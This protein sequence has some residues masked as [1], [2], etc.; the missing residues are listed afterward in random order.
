MRSELKDAGSTL[1]PA[2]AVVLVAAALAAV[3]FSRPVT[4]P[5]TAKRTYTQSVSYEYQ[6]EVPVG[7]TYP[8]GIVTTG[9]P[10]FLRLV[11]Q[12]QFHLAYQ[13]EARKLHGVVGTYSID[14]RVSG[15]GSWKGYIPLTERTRFTGESF[16]ADVTVDI[17]KVQAMIAATQAETGLRG[18]NVIIELVPHVKIGG[19]DGDAPISA[20]Y[21]TPLSLKVT[22]LDVSLVKDPKGPDDEV[23]AT[24]EATYRTPIDRVRKLSLF[25]RTITVERGRTIAAAGLFGGLLW[26]LI[27]GIGLRRSRALPEPARIRRRYH[28]ILVDVASVPDDL[29]MIELGDIDALARIAERGERLML[30]HDDGECHS[31]LVDDGGPTYRYRTR[32]PAAI[33]V[34]EPVAPDVVVSAPMVTEPAVSEPVVSEPEATEPIVTE[35]S[36]W[37]SYANAVPPPYA[38]TPPPY[39]GVAPPMPAPA[40]LQEAIGLTALTDAELDEL[41]R[42]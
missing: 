12:V 37:A 16:S 34:P 41:S 5:G 14:A 25:G 6:A 36:E 19:F 11:Q 40:T 29:D 30:H 28:S 31:Y 1:G 26:L 9:S 18:D 33:P 21:D 7:P 17:A 3:S 39:F 35:P 32:R 27:A 13:L 23:G 22:P 8:D 20:T 38:G 24:E 10:I 2:L 15:I 42:Q 4:V